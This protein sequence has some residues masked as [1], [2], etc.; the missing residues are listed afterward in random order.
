MSQAQVCKDILKVLKP[1]DVINQTGHPKWYQFWLYITYAAIR[2]HQRRLLGKHSNYRDT[3]TMMYLGDNKTF[4]VELPKATIKPVSTYC[5]SDMSIYRLKHKMTPSMVYDM[6]IHATKMEGESYDVGQLLDIAI[7]GILGYDHLRKVTTFDFG[8][9]K[10][11]CS[12]GVRVLFEKLNLERK[13]TKQDGKWLFRSLNPHIWPPAA[14]KKYKGTDV[15]ATT[16][17]HFAN[18][19]FFCQEFQLIAKFKNGKRTF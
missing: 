18:S 14:I 17:A 15:E 8:A 4:S 19:D 3:H 13:I 2:W 9:K 11:V 12:V 16:P 6:L 5:L 7:N 1:G 10:K